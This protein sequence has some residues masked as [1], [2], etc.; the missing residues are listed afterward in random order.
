MNKVIALNEFEK[1]TGRLYR[2]YRTLLADIDLLIDK[3]ENDHTQGVPLG[4][5]LRKLR[6]GTESKGGGKSGGFRVVTYFVEQT[7]EGDVVY[8]VTI[9]DKSEEANISKKELLKIIKRELD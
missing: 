6:L 2:K 4:S 9:F 8:L 5:G 3:L 7:K 1:H